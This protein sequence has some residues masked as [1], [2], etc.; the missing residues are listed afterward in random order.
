MKRSL[1]IVGM[2]T[3]GKSTVGAIVAPRL[4][5]DLWDS[6]EMAQGRMGASILDIFAGGR[7]GEFRRVEAQICLECLS[8]D[9]RL[10]VTGGGAI[11]D[12]RVREALCGTF[13]VW[14]DASDETVTNRLK[15]VDRPSVTG[16]DPVEEL[17]ELS[18]RR[19]PHYDEVARVRLFV[20]QMD[21]KAVCDAIEQSWKGL[22][23]NDFR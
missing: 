18:R 23:D 6:D 5:L 19:R 16:R 8:G 15:N 2:R 9:G 20:D 22:S 12:G 13:T 14:L 4:G 11:E 10:L 7:Q 17:A 21:T 1:A 3:V